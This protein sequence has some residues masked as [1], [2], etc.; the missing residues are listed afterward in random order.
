MASALALEMVEAGRI[1]GCSE[2]GIFNRLAIPIL[3]P[4]MATMAIF[5]MVAS[6]NSLFLPSVL[7]SGE[8]RTIPVYVSLLS[9]S[10]HHIETGAIFLGLS[11]T[12]IPLMAFYFL[13]SKQIIA[14]VSLGGLK[15]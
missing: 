9:G 14:G 13:L 5:A 4:G 8:W 7:L 12:T 15:E 3:R 10:R 1:D 11:M 6:W 2:F